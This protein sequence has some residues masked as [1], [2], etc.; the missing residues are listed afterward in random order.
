MDHYLEINLFASND[1]ALNV[2][3]NKAYSAI[4]FRLFELKSSDIGISFAKVS[5]WLGNVIRLHG[6]KSALALCA[7]KELFLKLPS[8]CKVSDIQAVPDKASH[9]N[10]SR[11]RPKLSESRLRRLIKRG[12]ISDEDVKAY[13]KKLFSLKA[14]DGNT[15]TDP[16]VEYV[17]ASN[18]HKHHRFFTF[19][20]LVDQPL[21][22]DFNAFGVSNVATVPCF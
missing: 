9:R 17:S 6:T 19:G 8:S 4:H 11:R 16:Y 1:E 20:E 2:Q 3:M 7:T 21:K 13:K 22:G 14:E 15:L 5:G 12:T 18:G 10:I